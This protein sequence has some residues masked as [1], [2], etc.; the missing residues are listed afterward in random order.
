MAKLDR[1]RRANINRDTGKPK[2]YNAKIIRIGGAVDPVSQSI[3]LTA[4]MDDSNDELLPGMSGIATF[5]PVEM[6]AEN[7]YEQ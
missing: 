7:P 5:V 2:R 3:Q 1:A 6:G 4:E